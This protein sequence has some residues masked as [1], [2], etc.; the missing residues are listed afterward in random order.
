MLILD[1]STS[2]VDAETERNLWHSLR[3]YLGRTTL[4]VIT[5]RV[6]TM[7]A[8]DRVMVLEEGRLEAIGTP[9]ELQVV[10][11]AYREIIVH[12]NYLFNVMPHHGFNR[13]NDKPQQ[14][15]KTLRRL[16]KY[17]G[18]NRLLLG[19]I[20]GLIVLNILCNLLGSYLLR[21]IINDYILPA[22]SRDWDAR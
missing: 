15:R 7:Q 21:P 3:A 14:G 13:S 1:D 12:N 4:L 18:Y 17:V 6:Q 11:P 10:S 2:A 22:I 9:E 19:I 5:Q 8:A 16:I 20:G